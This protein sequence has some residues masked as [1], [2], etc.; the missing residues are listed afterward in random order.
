[1]GSLLR[2][3]EAQSRTRSKEGGKEVGEIWGTGE[4]KG[5]FEKG[6]KEIAGREVESGVGGVVHGD[7]KIDNLVS[8]LHSCC[9]G[10]SFADLTRVPDLP[11]H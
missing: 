2:V 11:P 6:G 1:V 3:S 8:P 4:L 9:C 5:F 10:I 7:Y